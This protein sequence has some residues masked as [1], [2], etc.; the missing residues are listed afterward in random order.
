MNKVEYLKGQEKIFESKRIE[1]NLQHLDKIKKN[2]KKLQNNKSSFTCPLY[3]CFKNFPS[4]DLF[5]KHIH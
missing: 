5:K 2:I 4:L 1:E 3:T